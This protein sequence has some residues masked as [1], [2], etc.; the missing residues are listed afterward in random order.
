VAQ[1]KRCKHEKACIFTILSMQDTLLHVKKR[2]EGESENNGNYWELK[3]PAV[4][5]KAWHT[6]EAYHALKNHSHR[7]VQTRASQNW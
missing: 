5:K 1:H 4:L 7:I 2:N 6:P 3:I